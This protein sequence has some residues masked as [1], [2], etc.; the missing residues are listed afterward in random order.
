[1]YVAL[2]FSKVITAEHP[3]CCLECLKKLLKVET[4]RVLQLSFVRGAASNSGIGSA[5]QDVNKFYLCVID[6]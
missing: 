6:A 4:E 5:I 2:H 3:K 1:M